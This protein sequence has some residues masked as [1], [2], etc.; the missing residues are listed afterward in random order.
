MQPSTRH[1][2]TCKSKQV[3]RLRWPNLLHSRKRTCVC[4]VR[5]CGC[6]ASGRPLGR[7]CK[8]GSP[9]TI[10]RTHEQQVRLHHTQWCQ[11][12]QVGFFCNAAPEPFSTRMLEDAF[13]GHGSST[14]KGCA[15]A[16]EGCTEI[17]RLPSSRL[18]ARAKECYLCARLWK[19]FAGVCCANDLCQLRGLR[20]II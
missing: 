16:R 12:P 6:A 2:G 1:Q 11:S 17:I 19:V 3:P 9:S 8:V 10:L 4:C 5:A 20:V 14:R 15:H 7:G 13:K 18:E